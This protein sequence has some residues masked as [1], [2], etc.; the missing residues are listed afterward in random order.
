MNA[1]RL[2]LTG[3]AG[4]IGRHCL[5]ALSGDPSLEIH[6]VSSRD[7][8]AAPAAG[9][10]WH[11]CDL[12]RAADVESL[13]RRVAP[14][15]LLHLAWYT[16][17]GLYWRSLENYR[18]LEATVRL[19]LAF[20]ATGQRAVLAGTS[21][22]YAWGTDTCVE[23]VTPLRPASPYGV[24]KDAAR[25]VVLSLA[26]ETGVSACWARIFGVYGPGEPP[27]KLVSRIAAAVR[28]GKRYSVPA[29]PLVRDCLHVADAARA[30]TGLLRTPLQG[31]VN[32]GSGQA[33][34]VEEVARTVAR[35]VGR[36]EAI[37]LVG[38]GGDE[39]PHVVADIS[40]LRGTGWTARHSLEDGVRHAVAPL[41]NV[42]PGLGLNSGS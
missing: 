23:D 29:R 20:A 34:S 41:V 8:P 3:A 13:V 12:H 37:D 7:R 24:C 42:G 39:P 14:T 9:V 22:E 25:A 15:H 35:A 11:R 1:V 36:P 30:L 21:A 28:A 2:L 4:F 26:A 33:I 40:R 10:T 16:E 18:W 19:M 6:A 17:P 38:D 32:V 27:S 31:P 5:D